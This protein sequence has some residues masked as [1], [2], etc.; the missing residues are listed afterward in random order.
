MLQLSEISTEQSNNKSTS[1]DQMSTADILRLINEEDQ[2]VA[3]AVKKVIPQV[4][5]AVDEI[6]ERMERGGRLIYI[7]SGTSGRMG[8]LDA[9]ELPPTYGTSPDEIFAIMAGGRDAMFIAVEGAEDDYEKGQ[10]DLAAHEITEYDSVLGIAASGR[11]PYVLGALA[12]AKAAGALTLALTSVLGS[13]VAEAV[14]IAIVP[15][16]GPEV[17]T[18]STRM[19]SG[20]AQ[21]MVLNMLSTALMIKQGK[22]FGNLMV[23]VKASNEK[24]HHRA[25][26]IVQGVSGCTAE[27][28]KTLLEAADMHAKTAI[29]MYWHKLSAADARQ[30][31][32]EVGGQLSAL[33][34]TT[35]TTTSAPT[36]ATDQ[37][38]AGFAANDA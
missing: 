31:L 10:A 34:P 33:V 11:T 22:V 3:D 37:A 26:G 4:A 28:A 14:A 8:V 18:G 1:I 15:E 12:L 13:P 23:D 6:H 35:G 36:G 17:V 38:T 20:T 25:I 21:K 9:A 2:T 5:F 32:T 27:E 29:V 16:T 24:L 7:G 30:K 19:K